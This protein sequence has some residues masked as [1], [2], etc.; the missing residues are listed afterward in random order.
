MS[1]FMNPVAFERRCIRSACVVPLMPGKEY[2]TGGQ[3]YPREG[4]SSG[5][6]AAPCAVLAQYASV[7]RLAGAAHRRSR[8]LTVFMN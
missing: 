4:I 8:C 7:A 3:G 1:Q 6:G 5:S 2:G